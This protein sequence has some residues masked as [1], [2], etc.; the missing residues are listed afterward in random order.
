MNLLKTDVSKL[1]NGDQTKIVVGNAN[2]NGLQQP[3]HELKAYNA[4]NNIPDRAN[5]RDS[6]YR[7]QFFA[8]SKV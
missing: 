5:I 2:G 7:N 8:F 3:S 1:V 4:A 6:L